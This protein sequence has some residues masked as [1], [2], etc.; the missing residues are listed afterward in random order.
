MKR[1]VSILLAFIMILSLASCSGGKEESKPEGA[2]GGFAG[3]ANPWT[4]T[5][6]DTVF[7]KT[8]FRFVE[9]QGA[10][11][12]VFRYNDSD[13]L[14]EMQFV[15]NKTEWCARVQKGESPS[16]ISGMNYEW[17][18]DYDVR[19]INNSLEL[20]GKGHKAS[21]DN[22]KKMAYAGQWFY[23]AGR[24]NFSLSTVAE[25]NDEVNIDAVASEVFVPEN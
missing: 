2:A 18:E 14:A 15:L 24:Y 25:K 1:T 6:S 13:G 23:E 22:G 9:P 11:D 5:D 20:T 12:I 16:D 21:D 7:S 10:Y 3:M 17:S 4:D 19:I 8:G